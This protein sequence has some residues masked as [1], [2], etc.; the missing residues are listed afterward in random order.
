MVEH[1]KPCPFCGSEAKLYGTETSGYLHCSNDD[2]PVQPSIY[3]KRIGYRGSIVDA[4][5]AR[6]EAS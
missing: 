3:A 2:C 4:W 1:L 5:N 6:P